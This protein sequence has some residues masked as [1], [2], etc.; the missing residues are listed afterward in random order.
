MA[1]NKRGADHELSN[2]QT[3]KQKQ[4]EAINVGGDDQPATIMIPLH[5]QSISQPATSLHSSNNNN[6][7]A[8]QPSAQ[9]SS[10]DIQSQLAPEAQKDEVCPMYL[11]CSS[12]TRV[13][14][15]LQVGIATYLKVCLFVIDRNCF[16]FTYV[17][18]RSSAMNAT[19]TE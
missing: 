12:S 19:W 2:P 11:F 17:M 6:D 4:K 10:E 3:K 9:I 14:F 5:L 15:L 16:S 7:I 8:K 1:E 18:I 13:N